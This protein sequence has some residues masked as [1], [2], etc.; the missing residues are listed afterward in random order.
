VKEKGRKR[1]NKD[2]MENKR[3]KYIQ[4]SENKETKTLLRV[5]NTYIKFAGM[6]GVTL[7]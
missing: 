2:K 1:K 7:D 3:A 6:G 4:N 5:K